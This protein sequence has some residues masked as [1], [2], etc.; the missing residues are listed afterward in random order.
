MKLTEAELENRVNVSICL[1]L[2]PYTLN[3]EP[4]AKLQVLNRKSTALMPKP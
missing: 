3:P 1:Q 2:K 4:L